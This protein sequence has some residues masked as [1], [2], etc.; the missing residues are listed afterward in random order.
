M[1]VFDDLYYR[2]KNSRVVNEALKP[3]VHQTVVDGKVVNQIVVFNT[4]KHQHVVVNT[5]GALSAMACVGNNNT[6]ALDRI[7]EL[8]L[9]KIL[10]DVSCEFTQADVGTDY[11][12]LLQLFDAWAAI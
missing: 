1:S 5:G 9:L 7:T 4:P 6:I 2:A 11:F 10:R 3:R 8:E 12:E